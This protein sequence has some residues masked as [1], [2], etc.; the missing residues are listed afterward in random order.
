[1]VVDELLISSRSV[2]F[3]LLAF[4]FAM[5]VFPIGS[6]FLTVNTIFTGIFITYPF[7]T[8]KSIEG[9]LVIR[10][11]L[12]RILIIPQANH[13]TRADSLLS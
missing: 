9:S 7:L 12:Y 10:F 6:Y 3:K 5:V 2:I 1:M 8:M 4:T 11:S 13:H